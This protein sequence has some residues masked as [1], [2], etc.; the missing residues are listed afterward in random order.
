MTV[1]VF[2]HTPQAIR[3]TR[4]ATLNAIA[5][6]WHWLAPESEP[7]AAIIGACERWCIGGHRDEPFSAETMVLIWMGL[8]GAAMILTEV[9][10]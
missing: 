4:S 7:P 5:S 6:C 1:K 9:L 3:W 2:G 8:I 10:R